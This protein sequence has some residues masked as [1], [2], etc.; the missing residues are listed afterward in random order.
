VDEIA[1]QLANRLEANPN[2]VQAY[3]ALKAHYLRTQDL[4]SLTNLIAGWAGYQSDPE[5]ASRGYFEASRVVAQADPKH[6]RRLALLRQAVALDV[7]YQEALQDLIELLPR[8]RDEQ[9]LAGFLEEHL[10]AMEEGQSDARLMA[11][12]YA[13]L[14]ALWSD[15]LHQPDTARRSYE[16]ALGL[17][18]SVDVVARVRA[19]AEAHGDRKLLG[20]ALAAEAELEK[21]PARKAELYYTL[22][23]SWKSAPREHD[24]VVNALT[25]AYNIAPADSSAPN[26]LELARELAEAYTQRAPER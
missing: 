8:I 26:A 2:D 7:G 6:E 15:K 5:K 13:Q 24:E 14:G 16:R 9:T 18:P 21:D 19:A 11:W 25:T 1:E 20:Q 23:K 4:A 3:E 17:N 22:A 10:R 12:L